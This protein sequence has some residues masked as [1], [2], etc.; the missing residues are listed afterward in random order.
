MKKTI[1]L[2]RHP[3]A[4][5]AVPS[6]E[7]VA[8]V[9]ERF[10]MP[11]PLPLYSNPIQI[12]KGKGVWVYDEKGRKYLDGFAGVATVSIGHSHPHFVRQ[13]TE[14]VEKLCHTTTLYMHHAMGEL[15]QRIVEKAKAVNPALESVYFANSGTEANETAAM[16]AKNYTGSHE[17]VAL[18]H[19]Y[20]GRTLMTM[21]L[22]GQSAWRHSGPF[23]LGVCH[24]P[25]NYTYRRPAGMRPETF[26]KL[27]VSEL[28]ET[29][30]ASTSGRLAAF[31]AEP[32]AGV[33]GT[34]VPEPEYFPGA[35]EV[36]KRYGG[37]CVADE[38]QTGVGRT[39]AFYGIEH[40]GVKPDIL[41]MAKGIGN[42]I[43]LAAVVTTREIAGAMKGKLHFNTYGGNP[44][45][46]A[47]GL[48]VLDVVEKEKLVERAAE[49]GGR[50]LERLGKI[51]AKS[52]TVGDVRGKGLMIGVEL[53]L[54][55]TTKE[56]N[57]DAT[58]KVLEG[59]K[60]R[61]VL[62]GKGGMAN[63]VLRLAPPLCLTAKEADLIADAVEE[64][65]KQV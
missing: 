56:P 26:A 57:P 60:E 31:F 30:R 65:L 53:V 18:R 45:S 23:A 17:F 16:L 42:G 32:I 64:S 39:G 36:I 48:A 44:V 27:C 63:N 49:V 19:S 11:L 22:T 37:L 62:V 25:A 7:D 55:K 8:R 21:A 1:L 35:Y 47:A 59:C 13:V 20:H 51:A 52:P 40:W 10:I 5:G 61:G 2:E 50:L 41:T 12:V 3:E 14:Q 58:M 28:E 33:G 4:N 54:D 43:P 15:A 29:I 9:R 46:M 24:A 38:V 6:A 34:I